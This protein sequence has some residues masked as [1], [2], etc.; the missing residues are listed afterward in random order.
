[1]FKSIFGLKYQFTEEM[2]GGSQAKY[3]G[4]IYRS[5]VKFLYGG[6]LIALMIGA[7]AIL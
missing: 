3:L 4:E 1:M 7:I 2:A 5:Q 6:G